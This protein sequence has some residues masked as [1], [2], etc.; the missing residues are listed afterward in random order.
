[1]PQSGRA[2]AN[3]LAN[4]KQHKHFD[5]GGLHFAVY[6]FEMFFAEKKF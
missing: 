4:G 1:M 6:A 5:E 3:L 2:I